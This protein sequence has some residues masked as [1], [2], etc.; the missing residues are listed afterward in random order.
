MQKRSKILLVSGLIVLAVLLTIPNIFWNFSKSCGN[1]YNKEF[2]LA[3]SELNP[4]ICHNIPSNINFHKDFKDSLFCEVKFE[5]DSIQEKRRI[6]GDHYSF[7]CITNLAIATQNSEI[8]NE[9]L[10][11]NDSGF[12]RDQCLI[13]FN[14]A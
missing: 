8:C 5:V 13:R 14:Q 10:N 1:S 11:L 9:L 6:S 4:I 7:N 2:N 3:A 12:T